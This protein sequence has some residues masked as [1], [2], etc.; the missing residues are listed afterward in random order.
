MCI[1]I[2]RHLLM[3]IKNPFVSSICT[4]VENLV[5]C[6]NLTSLNNDSGQKTALYSSC[7]TETLSLLQRG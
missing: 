5:K 2:T 6:N 7:R 3:L 4:F 1:L